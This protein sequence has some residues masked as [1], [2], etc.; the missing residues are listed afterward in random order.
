MS[1][2]R[3]TGVRKRVQINLTHAHLK[4]SRQTIK[5]CSLEVKRNGVKMSSRALLSFIVNCMCFIIMT[6]WNPVPPARRLSPISS[7]KR[8][9]RI[10]SN[11]ARFGN[12][13][14]KREKSDFMVRLADV[15]SQVE[16]MAATR[17]GG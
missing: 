10:K 17:V 6:T 3:F 12:R 13:E 16:T 9:E 5:E 11:T 8:I 14:K 4:Q 7:C 15:L 1:C 2:L